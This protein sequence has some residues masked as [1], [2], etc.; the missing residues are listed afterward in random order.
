M[1][2]HAPAGEP[3]TCWPRAATAQ[4]VPV[5]PSAHISVSRS[6][7]IGPVGDAVNVDGV[8]VVDGDN[9]AEGDPDVAAAAVSDQLAGER[10][11]DAV[12][13]LSQCFG[14]KP[15]DG[16]R[17]AMTG[18]CDGLAHSGTGQRVLA[19]PLVDP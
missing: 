2:I 3:S 9:D 4:S 5:E 12:G 18:D 1:A 13:V 11:G 10:L 17:L 8:G 14:H 15:E 7:G 19:G 16:G 6:V